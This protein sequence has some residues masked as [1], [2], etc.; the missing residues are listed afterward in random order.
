MITVMVVLYTEVMGYAIEDINMALLYAINGIKTTIR[1]N[2]KHE[3]L[4]IQ[5]TL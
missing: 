3:K 1:V 2:R 4:I 5:K